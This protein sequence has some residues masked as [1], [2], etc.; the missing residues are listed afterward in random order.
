MRG[1]KSSADSNFDAGVALLTGT[2]GAYDT[3]RA[4]EAF[5]RG[6]ARGHRASAVMCELMK[7]MSSGDPGDADASVIAD[8]LSGGLEGPHSGWMMGKINELGLGTGSDGGDAARMYR[9]SAEDGSVLGIYEV[10]K[11]DPGTELLERAAGMGCVPAMKAL[12]DRLLAEDD[13]ASRDRAQDLYADGAAAGSDECAVA[14]AWMRVAGLDTRRSNIDPVELLEGPAERGSVS[15]Q[16]LLA[17]VYRYGIGVTRS[18]DRALY[19]FLQASDGGSSYA[20]CQL[21]M[22]YEFGVGVSQS[23]EMACWFYG[24]SDDPVSASRLGLLREH[25]LGVDRSDA[26]AYEAY[27]GSDFKVL[28]EYRLGVMHEEE[29]LDLCSGD[30]AE[31]YKA[32]AEAGN[33]VAMYRLARMY[34]GR[35]DLRQQAFGLCETAALYGLPDAEVMMAEFYQSGTVVHKDLDR[36]LWWLDLA[37]VHGHPE[38]EE[39]AEKIRSGLFYTLFR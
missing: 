24:Q 15:A 33:P 36:A 7:V 37:R 21:G 4:Y 34:V 23:Y 17:T 29:R 28:S 31:H 11:R 22:M 38:A 20:K 19:W 39:R 3:E 6:A 18:D 1:P 2:G 35:R 10:G 30:T 32:A 9:R 26:L 12:G 5:F 16:R 14:L 25:G 27:R 8:A 13:P